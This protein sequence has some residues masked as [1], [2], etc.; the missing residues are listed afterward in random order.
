MDKAM[1]RFAPAQAV[2][3]RG[4][5]EKLKALKTMQRAL[6]IMNR[7]AKGV[8]GGS[9][10]GEKVG[11]AVSVLRSIAGI[12]GVSHAAKLS[13]LGLGMLKNLNDLR[14]AYFSCTIGIGTRFRLIHPCRILPLLPCRRRN[15]EA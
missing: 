6:T 4:Q 10:T 15:G 7:T 12:P 14:L 1:R 11:V 2:L 9:D 13:K 3:Y 5:P 8:T